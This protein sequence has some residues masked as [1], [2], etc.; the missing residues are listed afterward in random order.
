MKNR[1][2]ESK[3]NL[4]KGLNYTD[5]QA[6]KIIFNQ[7]H[8]KLCNYVYK[9]SGDM[10]LSKDLVQDVFIKIWEKQNNLN[11][12][13]SLKSYLYRAC[14]NEFLMHLRTQ[15]KEIDM[16]DLLKIQAL[17]ETVYESE[18]NRKEEYL[19]QLELAIEKLPKKRKMVLKLSRFESKKNK[20]IAELLGISHR[21]IETHLSKAIKFLKAN[22]HFF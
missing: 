3:A 5:K 19:I 14:H 7:Y 20:E 1:S 15:K 10:D 11:I 18:E 4:I 2:Q 12:N 17:S 16:L 6:F 8:T 22:S 9:L 21:T 13:S